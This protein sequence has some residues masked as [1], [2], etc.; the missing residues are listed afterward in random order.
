MA[1][2]I[3]AGITV[4]VPDDGIS[5]TT[6]PIGDEGRAFDGTFRSTVS[7]TKRTWDVTTSL[8]DSGDAATLKAALV[9]SP[10]ATASGDAMGGTVTV[11][12]RLVR[13]TPG[14][15]ATYTSRLVFRLEEA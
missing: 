6:T 14:P 10:T 11:W 1:F 12:P 7:T 2:L 3:V 9:A 15:T 4:A 13:E 8:L 5:I